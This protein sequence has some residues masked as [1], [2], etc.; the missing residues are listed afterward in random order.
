MHVSAR[1]LVG[2][3]GRTLSGRVR[4]G[5]TL[6]GWLTSLDQ[7]EVGRRRPMDVILGVLLFVGV[8]A[9]VGQRPGVDSSFVVVV[10]FVGVVWPWWPAVGVN[11]SCRDADV[12]SRSAYRKG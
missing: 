10:A 9:R 4:A 7:A 8:V 2:S 6:P 1:R 11:F 12:C 5:H 3:L